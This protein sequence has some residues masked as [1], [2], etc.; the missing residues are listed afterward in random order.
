M[1]GLYTEVI[2]RAN[3]LEVA[4]GYGISFK[5][6]GANFKAR[7]PFHL[8]KTPSFFVN[9][10]KNVFHCFGCNKS[11][12]TVTFVAEIEKIP[13]QEALKKLATKLGI[14]I[15]YD[16]ADGKFKSS[17]ILLELAK[18]LNKILKEET[19]RVAYNYLKKR[20]IEDRFIDLYLLGY[21][22]R[23]NSAYDNFMDKKDILVN[24]GIFG[25]D[26]N[27]NIYPML[28]D[29][30]IFPIYDFLGRVVAFGGR[31]LYDNP[32]SPKYLNTRE[33]KWFEKKAIFYA[34]PDY[35][36]DISKAQSAI[37]VE[38]YFDQ[39]LLNQYGF[40]NTLGILGSAFSI[41]HVNFLEKYVKKVYFFFD[42]DEAG[43]KSA[44][45]S[46]DI[47]LNAGF[48]SFFVT[49][50]TGLDP[51]DLVL[52]YGREKM[53]S[54]INSAKPLFEFYCETLKEKV[55]EAGNLDEKAQY[56]DEGIKKISTIHNQIKRELY[57][58][59]FADIIGINIKTIE[60][61]LN[62]ILQKK[63]TTY[64]IFYTMESPDTKKENRALYEL[65]AELIFLISKDT[66][67]YKKAENLKI[68]D[69]IITPFY[70][71]LY[72]KISNMEEGKTV[73]WMDFIEEGE[74]NTPYLSYL[75]KFEYL[76]DYEISG[77][78]LLNVISNLKTIVTNSRLESIKGEQLEET[79]KLK[80]E[81]LD[82]LN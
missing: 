25:I 74:D 12:N 10:V 77:Q 58:S 69:Y 49:T 8:E 42:E 43:R 27:N 81:I 24:L 26:E 73:D 19:S 78:R 68:K 41:N 66:D 32:N 30:V 35:V 51:S 80:K 57:L 82:L 9:P 6:T 37:I 70:R 65:Q 54:Y 48:E 79:L 2:K 44:I 59:W 45:N 67:L 34:H 18:F 47:I 71:N 63:P 33:N 38:G 56:I 22:P 13:V 39:I 55:K 15:T 4:Q 53:E 76:D 20:G 61:R 52:Q 29:R 3:L 14:K 64:N 17:E 36:K 75:Y 50:N 72:E 28:K 11:G 21:A 1:A 60:E 31:N 46:V 62:S 40:S 5:K 16:Y 23:D 7:C